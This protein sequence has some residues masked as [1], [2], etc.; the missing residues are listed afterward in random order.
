M[1]RP[2][3]LN[4][5]V[6]TGIKLSRGVALLF[7]LVVTTRLGAQATPEVTTEFFG[8]K[9]QTLVR[10][11]KIPLDGENQLGAFYT[12]AGR[13]QQAPVAEL[14]LHFVRSGAQWAYASGHDVV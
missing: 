7:A 13:A 14:T 2:L 11:G 4:H 9:G 5:H 6:R 1:T 10:M 3:A 12:F 8:A